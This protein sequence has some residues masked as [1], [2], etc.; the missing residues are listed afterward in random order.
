MLNKQLHDE[1]EAFL[2]ANYYEFDEE[3]KY[4]FTEP[5]LDY[6]DRIS[7]K[8]LNKVIYSDDP[9]Q[10]F[11]E[12][13]WD[14]YTGCEWQYRNDIVSEFMKT[15]EGSKYD[16]EEVDDEL[17]EM[18]YFKIPKEHY[19]GQEV[20]V[21]IV[22]DTGDLNYDYTLN[23]VYPHYNGH[24]DDEIDDKAS[25]VW[26]AKTQ[27]YTKEQLQNY[28]T[29]GKDKLDVKGFLETVYQEVI[30]CSTSCPALFIP[31]KMTVRQLLKINKII[32]AR[33]KNGY[34]YEPSKRKDCG[35][36]VIGKN[37]DCALYDSWEGGGGCW[38]VELE[39]D[40]EL[41]IK[42]I[43]KAIPDGCLNYSMQECYGV[44][45]NCWK[46]ALKEIKD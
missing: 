18:W 11:E 26:L 10:A 19:L 35:S 36:L 34:I 43:Q 2:K 23:A 1:L 33:D 30:N 6:D 4:F 13:L 20:N 25:L 17:V 7:D 28:L 9:E 14:C 40:F 31:I 22:V 46:D 29:N 38:G 21:D 24:K 42:F 16:Y 45:S 32:N 44:T 5:Q 3:S 37:V 39:K 27:G 41:P 8:G 15:P 12:M